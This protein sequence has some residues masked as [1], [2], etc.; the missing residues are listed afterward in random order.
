MKRA[1]LVGALSL[2][3][4]AAAPAPGP[5]RA[6]FSLEALL[7]DGPGYVASHYGA[8]EIPDAL[9][10]DLTAAGFTCTSTPAVRA[11]TRVRPPATPAS[12]CFYV[13]G[14]Y[15]YAHAPVRIER[16][17]PRCLGAGPPRR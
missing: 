8:D 1:C 2:A 16:G 13:D 11:C 9:I 3:A 5:T 7:G 12:P 6:P 10:A 14:V 17:A 4:C 15:V